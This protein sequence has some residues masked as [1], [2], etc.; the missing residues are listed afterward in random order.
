VM[1]QEAM[2]RFKSLVEWL[3][4]IR[5]KLERALKS[6]RVIPANIALIERY[7]RQAFAQDDTGTYRYKVSYRLYLRQL[8]LEYCQKQCWQC[9]D[10]LGLH[11]AFDSVQRKQIS[12]ALDAAMG[13][14]SVAPGDESVEEI[15][16]FH[17]LRQDT[18]AAI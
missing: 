9:A 14:W 4:Q 17:L 7:F 6:E 18:M 1:G 13:Y 3:S 12:D 11:H 5:R 2:N 16:A 8:L 15:P 10:P